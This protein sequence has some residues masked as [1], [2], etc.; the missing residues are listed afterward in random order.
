MIRT[1][2]LLTAML[3]LA[4]A[5]SPGCRRQASTPPGAS[6]A[7]RF[8]VTYQTVNNPFF[9]ELHDGLLSVIEKRG[10]RLELFDARF[11]AQEQSNQLSDM[12]QS[13][14]DGIFLNP[15][16]WKGVGRSLQRAKQAGIPVVVI[17]APVQDRS[18][19][20]TTVA[21][22]NREAG[23]LAARALQK[24]LPDG[25]RI[26]AVTLSVNKAC[27]D[28]V[29][30][31]R[32]VIDALESCEVIA[33]QDVSKGNAEASYPAVKDLLLREPTANAIFA[34]ND[35]TA[36]GALRALDQADRTKDVVVVA[37]DGCRK[38]AEEIQA[39]RMLG[40]T[41]QFADEIGQA[42]ASA[43]YDH[44]AGKEVPEE[45]GVRVEWVDASNAAEFL[46]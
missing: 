35:P 44:L 23:R 45:I 42:A 38:A 2:P 34:I 19:A 26:L 18:L 25:A 36:F 16:N 24:E 1:A 31:F 37:V 12:I 43:M 10:D 27:R 30:G 3:L 14:F 6:G 40:S 11:N 4:S 15:V 29:A 13:G 5:L 8:A 20:V 9:R 39:G 21:S 41:A 28:R 17:D 46:K 22:D 7:R 33:E 32:E